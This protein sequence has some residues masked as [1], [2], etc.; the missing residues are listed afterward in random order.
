DAAVWIHDYHLQLVPEFLRSARPDL[1]IG[2]FNHIP[3]PP[4]QLFQ[5]LPWRAEI[6]S[7]L[8]GAGVLGF[9]RLQGARNFVVAAER[10][11]GAVENQPELLSV[12]SGSD[13]A[14]HQVRV[15]H[16]PISID[17]DEFELA[18]SGRDARR[19]SAQ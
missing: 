12:P 19:Q 13:G 17:V 6:V 11:L 15:G 10:L 18:A 3:W 9:Q 2:W 14:D 1:R 7:G 5:R 4:I 16:Y 8:L